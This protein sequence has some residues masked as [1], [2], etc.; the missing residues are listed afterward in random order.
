MTFLHT[1]P[2]IKTSHVPIP[3]ICYP[4]PKL[5]GVAVGAVADL[6]IRP[7]GALII[8]SIAGILSTIGYA[9]ITVLIGFMLSKL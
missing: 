6:M 3:I 9:Y 7:Y 4:I 8:G 5:G 2:R 1:I